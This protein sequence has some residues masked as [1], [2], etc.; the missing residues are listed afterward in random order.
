M[1]C[2]FR[3]YSAVFKEI[4]KV[5]HNTTY[6][7]NFIFAIATPKDLVDVV[8]YCSVGYR[9]AKLAQILQEKIKTD[10]EDDNSIRVYNLEGSLFKW[11]NERRPMIDKHGNKTEFCH[12][13]SIIWGKFLDSTLRKWSP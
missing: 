11:A 7:S 4:I 10:M 5:L 8:C 12:P 6:C 13:Y 2:S 1:H 9:S 3:S